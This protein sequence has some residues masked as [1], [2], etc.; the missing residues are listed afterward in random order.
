MKHTSKSLLVS[1]TLVSLICGLALTQQQVKA[2]T[3]NPAS[4]KN[5][6]TTTANIKSKSRLENSNTKL[7]D[8]QNTSSAVSVKNDEAEKAENKNNK[9]TDENNPGQKS[10]TNPE[11]IDEGTWGTSKWE[12]KH[13]GENYHL[14]LHAGTLGKPISYVNG[15][16]GLNKGMSDKLTQITIDPGVV[17]NQNSSYLFSNLRSLKSIQGLENL[18]TS[19]VVYMTFMFNN[20]NNLTKLNLSHFVT[21]KVTYMD[22]MFQDCHNLINLDLS[23]FNTENVTNFN[24]MFANCINL[25]KLDLSNF[26]TE[27]VTNFESMFANCTNLTDL[28]ISN[29]VINNEIIDNIFFEDSK[30]HHLVLGPNTNIPSHFTNLPPV[31]AVG[32]KI[33]GTNNVVAEPYWIATSGYRKGNKYISDELFQM[34]NRDQVTVYDWVAKPIYS[35]TTES[36][37]VTRFIVLHQENKQDEIETQTVVIKRKIKINADGSKTY[38]EWTPEEWSEYKLPEI[39]GYLP[40]VS[41]VPAEAVDG[42]TINKTVDVY[43][44]PV[45]QT[46]TIQY[47]DQDKIVGTQTVKGYTGHT[48]KP[49]LQAPL[50][51]ELAS[52]TQP[53]FTVDASGKQVVQVAVIHKIAQ[54]IDSKTFTRTINIHQ[55]DGTEKSFDQVALIRRTSYLDEVT[56]EKSYGSW[57]NDSWD[58]FNVPEIAGYTPS[59]EIVPEK[60]VNCDSNNEQID[61]YYLPNK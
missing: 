58:E 28:N 14:Y 52:T 23:T 13:E 36:K 45:E 50:G 17:A 12:Y 56:G 26:K 3:I 53:T 39:K 47:M 29:F 9:N 22:V 43:Y 38:G 21:S 18:D 57:H 33:P 4:A 37:A 51:Y 7:N 48:I 15:I 46:I 40:N 20:C 60:V 31:P 19:N 55:P 54:S 8:F 10:E 35:E 6:I 27:K 49:D 25:K 30:L 2:D 59:Q 11:L 34:K 5:V 61:I 32:T 41:I 24:S 16:A 44:E 42:N 1:S